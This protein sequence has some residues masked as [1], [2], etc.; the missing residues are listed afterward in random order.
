MR[1]RRTGSRQAGRNSKGRAPGV[2]TGSIVGIAF[3][4]AGCTQSSSEP[5]PPPPIPVSAVLTGSVYPCVGAPGLTHVEYERLRDFI[6]VSRGG[7][8]VAHRSGHGTMTYRFALPPGRYVLTGRA[9]YP[10]TNRER[11]SPPNGE[12][13][14]RGGLLLGHEGGTS[15]GVV[16]PGARCRSAGR[17][18]G[19]IRAAPHAGPRH[20]LAVAAR[21]SRPGRRGPGS[22]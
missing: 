5:S 6:T 2:V 12:D 21:P 3:V 16:V 9:R 19:L 13:R 18:A 1:K 7:R 14:P 10:P 15:R 17:W 8:P 20:T 22:N 11:G 4:L